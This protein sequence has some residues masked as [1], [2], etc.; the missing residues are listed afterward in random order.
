MYIITPHRLKRKLVVRR[1]LVV[2]TTLFVLFIFSRFMKPR[3]MGSLILADF[4]GIAAS[5]VEEISCR[6]A[7]SADWKSSWMQDGNLNLIH[8]HSPQPRRHRIV[9]S[10]SY[11]QHIISSFSLCTNSHQAGFNWASVCFVLN[12]LEL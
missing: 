1:S 2:V 9:W 6:M 8:E 3:V 12:F 10:L 5:N 11:L 4:A 7:N